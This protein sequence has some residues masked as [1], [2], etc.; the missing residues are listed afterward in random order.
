MANLAEQEVY[1]LISSDRN[2]YI[3]TIYRANIDE[4][5]WKIKI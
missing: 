4:K 3:T 5:D 2:M 1:E